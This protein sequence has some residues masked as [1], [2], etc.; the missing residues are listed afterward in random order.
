MKSKLNRDE[1]M[2]N[3]FIFQEGKKKRKKKGEGEWLMG[4]DCHGCK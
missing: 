1:M 2:R 3:F 4:C